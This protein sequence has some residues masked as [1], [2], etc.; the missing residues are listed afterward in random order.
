MTLLP[1][2]SGLHESTRARVQYSSGGVSSLEGED[3]DEDVGD[4]KVGYSS[5]LGR[6]KI[7]SVD[8]YQRQTA[9]LG[10]LPMLGQAA[11]AVSLI[12]GICA[13]LLV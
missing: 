3:E 6:V 7:L 9:G 12:A 10:S 1:K 11:L 5:S 13:N 8:E 2:L 4:M